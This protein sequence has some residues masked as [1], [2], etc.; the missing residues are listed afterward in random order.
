MRSS[1]T[2]ALRSTAK[3]KRGNAWY[4][5][6]LPACC[7][8]SRTLRESR[9]RPALDRKSTRLNSSHVSISYA[10]FCLKKKKKGTARDERRIH[11]LSAALPP[12]PLPGAL[13]EDLSDVP[14][15]REAG[16]VLRTL[17]AAVSAAVLDHS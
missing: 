9:R 3:R 1:G 7:N 10:V 8:T 4:P 13:D 15:D 6:C 5:P 11:H 12:L 2:P 16:A 17:C 14:A